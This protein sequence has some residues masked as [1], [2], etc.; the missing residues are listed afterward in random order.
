MWLLLCCCCCW[1]SRS[2]QLRN[3]L[4]PQMGLQRVRVAAGFANKY[5]DLLA[6]PC[7]SSWTYCMLLHQLA[8]PQSALTSGYLQ[9][10]EMAVEVQK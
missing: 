2:A 9:R 3:L 1:L 6:C 8:M 5:W 7:W 10:L 4:S